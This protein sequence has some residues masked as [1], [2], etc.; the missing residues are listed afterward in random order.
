MIARA[1][2]ILVEGLIDYSGFA[3]PAALP[4][5][6]AVRNYAT[7]RGSQYSWLLGR[8]IIPLAKLAEYESALGGLE[9]QGKPWRLSA[10]TTGHALADIEAIHTFNDRHANRAVIDAIELKAE[11]P[12]VIRALRPVVPAN[13]KAYVEIPLGGELPALVA[14]LAANG[15]RGKART[16][17]LTADAIPSCAQ[18]AQF[19][20]ACRAAKIPLKFTAGMHA[21]LRSV[22][23]LTY[24]ADSPTTAMHGFVNAFLAAALAWQGSDLKTITE[25][26]AATGPEAFHFDDERA[27]WHDV[28]VSCEFLEAAR[29]GFAISLGSCSFTEPIE[30]LQ[31]LGWM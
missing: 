9:Y 25:L 18:V 12:D 17:G 14:A 23:K 15:F 21:P 26:L 4:M 31:A 16:G 24:A 29:R 30:G 13:L 7:Y 19:I 8:S 22:R 10:L 20:V 5:A 3:P 2:R 11:T 28:R 6:D 27:L 1:L